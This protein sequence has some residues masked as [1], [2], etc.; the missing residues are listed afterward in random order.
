MQ[1]QMWMNRGADENSRGRRGW[2]T[3]PLLLLIFLWSSSSA[4]AQ[5]VDF[6]LDTNTND[7]FTAVSTTVGGFDPGTMIPVTETPNGNTSTL[8]FDFSLGL[9]NVQF[10]F[11]DERFEFTILP[12]DEFSLTLDKSTCHINENLTDPPVPVLVERYT[13]NPI[14]PSSTET[15]MMP[16]S[17]GTLTLNG[18]G[19][20]QTRDGLPIDPISGDVLIRGLACL[21]LVSEPVTFQFSGVLPIEC[22]EPS[23]A[24]LSGAAMLTLA[25]L[26]RL[27]RRR[28]GR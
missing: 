6:D 17:T 20:N 26:A 7:S 22:P 8:D 2:A 23:A 19:G 5:T 24:G 9:P 28:Q 16:I 25:G 15:I 4:T 21:N 18:C 13:K 11:P 12:S 27:R 1:M 3:G 10:F 14:V